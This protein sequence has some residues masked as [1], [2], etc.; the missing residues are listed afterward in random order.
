MPKPCSQTSPNFSILHE[1][2]R[3]LNFAQGVCV[4]AN[5][6]EFPLQRSN[7]LV[8]CFFI[9][10][11]GKFQYYLV[12]HLRNKKQASRRKDQPLWKVVI[13]GDKRLLGRIIHSPS[14]LIITEPVQASDVHILRKLMQAAFPL[15]YPIKWGAQE[16]INILV[17]VVS[18]STQRGQ[19][20]S[21]KTA[22][23]I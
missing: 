10:Q 20:G 15:C 23:V 18:T 12:I 4:C 5:S 1:P 21:L 13:S 17:R 3:S 8:G 14:K 9:Y 22:A 11:K 16:N 19:P 2:I 6:A 7:C